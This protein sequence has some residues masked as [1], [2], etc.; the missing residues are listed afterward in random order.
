M[1]WSPCPEDDPW[2]WEAHLQGFLA[3]HDDNSLVITTTLGTENLPPPP[4]LQPTPQGQ[5]PAQTL[6]SPGHSPKTNLQHGTRAGCTTDHMTCDVQR[7]RDWTSGHPS[8]PLD[9]FAGKKIKNCSSA[10]TSSSALS[11]SCSSATPNPGW[12]SSE[13]FPACDYSSVSSTEELMLLNCS[14]GEDSWESLG[15]QGD[16]ASLS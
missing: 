13:I 9:S 5:V 16:P 3:V 10:S 15:L 11:M 8:E 6:I 7:E 2:R 14:V 1:T 4:D 12:L